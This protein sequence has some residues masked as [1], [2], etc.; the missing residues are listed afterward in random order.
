MKLE[1]TEIKKRLLHHIDRISNNTNSLIKTLDFVESIESDSENKPFINDEGLAN[2]IKD[3]SGI[4]V[5]IVCDDMFE[6]IKD[7]NSLS[8]GDFLSD[9]Y[10]SEKGVNEETTKAIRTDFYFGL[11]LLE[12]DKRGKNLSNS[13]YS[14]IINGISNGEIKLR[15][16]V[17]EFLLKGDFPVVITTIGFP[18]IESALSEK[19]YESEW[20]NPNQR[21]DLPFVKD[22]HSRVVYHIFGGATSNAWV[23]NEQTLLKYVHAL[24]TGDFCAK[25]LANYLRG[26]GNENVKR[27]LVLGSTLPDWLF[28]FF[29]YPLYGDKFSE[30]N[31]YWMSLDEIEKGLDMF[32]NRNRYTGQTN[33]RNENRIDT[34]LSEATPENNYI[35]P[36]KQEPYKI[37]VSYKREKM[38]SA[39]AEIIERIYELLRKQAK[40]TGGSVWRD[41][42]QVSDGGNPY[43]ANIKKAIKDCNLFIPIVS[44]PY[45][46]EFIDAPDIVNY[47]EDPIP[48]AGFNEANDDERVKA[49]NPVVREAYYA[50]AYGKKCAPIIITNKEGTLNG[51]T[52]EAINKSPIDNRNIPSYIFGE[53]TNLVHDDNNPKFFNLPQID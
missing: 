15:E 13:I 40:A 4:I 8:I 23:Y 36:E 20:Y 37:F 45:L 9:K 44:F 49:L 50:I 26:I 31:G 24:H 47:A 16:S 10:K 46:D 43:W 41:I 5:P 21:N 3:D 14:A 48:N 29:V 28:R 35:N 18:I 17:K 34:I 52:T 1:V 25:N 11:S 2:S 32:L 6:Y 33:L 38:N 42:E 12:Q 19:G 7:G 30:S 22:E 27:P 53:H 39:N 51:G